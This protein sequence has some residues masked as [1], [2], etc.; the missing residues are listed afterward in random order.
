MEKCLLATKN[1]S[2]CRMRPSD[3]GLQTPAFECRL[4][5]FVY[6]T[7]FIFHWFVFYDNNNW[8]YRKNTIYSEACRR[9]ERAGNPRSEVQCDLIE[10]FTWVTYKVFISLCNVQQGSRN[11]QLYGTSK[12]GNTWLRGSSLQALLEKSSLPA[13][14]P[15]THA[16]TTTAFHKPL[17]IWLGR[18]AADNFL[19]DK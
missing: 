14:R 3:C 4:L 8:V 2:D 10:T 12:R 18:G 13:P 5:T 1:D 7:R 17:S 16:H 19:S 9:L 15:Q 6:C 11:H